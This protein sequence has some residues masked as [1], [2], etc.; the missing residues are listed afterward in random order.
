MELLKTLEN[1]YNKHLDVESIFEE[2]MDLFNPDHI[3]SDT[4]EFM[5]FLLNKLHEEVMD[6]GIGKVSLLSDTI[7]KQHLTSDSFIS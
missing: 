4:S 2:E 1:K 6:L 3:M 7:K 5:S